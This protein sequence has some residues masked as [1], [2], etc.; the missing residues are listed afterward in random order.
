MVREKRN[1]KGGQ[2]EKYFVVHKE[3][4]NSCT[5]KTSCINHRVGYLVYI[6]DG[7]TVVLRSMQV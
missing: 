3:K 6:Q 1:G 7:E 5:A 4:K 2:K